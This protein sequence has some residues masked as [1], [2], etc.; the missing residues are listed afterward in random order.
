M[1]QCCWNV[2]PA[3]CLT[4]H[5][6]VHCFTCRVPLPAPTWAWC[7]TCTVPNCPP[8]CAMFHLYSAFT[9]AEG[10]KVSLLICD[11]WLTHK[12]A[13]ITGSTDSRECQIHPTRYSAAAMGW[14]MHAIHSTVRE[15]AGCTAAQ[16]RHMSCCTVLLHSS[17]WALNLGLKSLNQYPSPRPL[18]PQQRE[19][20]RFTLPIGR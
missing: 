8:T 13:T 12:L 15:L 7:F 11:R 10:F 1:F 20:R 4:V 5:L 2:S 16:P 17:G 14:R 3:Q 19:T 9:C 18:T 6:P